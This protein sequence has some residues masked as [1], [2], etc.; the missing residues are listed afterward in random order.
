VFSSGFFKI[1]RCPKCWK[2]SSQISGI[3]KKILKV[4]IPLIIVFVILSRVA[5]NL[6]NKIVSHITAALD[7]TTLYTYSKDV[8]LESVI[9]GRQKNRYYIITAEV[10]YYSSILSKAKLNTGEP[11]GVLPA[12]MTAELGS[13][14][15]RGAEVWIPVSFYIKDKPQQAFALFPRDWEKMVSVYNWDGEVKKIRD[16]YQTFV[17]KNFELMEVQPKDEK[18]YKEKYNDYYKVKDVGDK[19]FFYASRTDKPYID[20][21]YSYY[22]GRNSINAVLLQADKAWERP[23][24]EIKKAEEEK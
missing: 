21:V 20:A 5:P 6:H 7:S 12:K 18:A 1:T 8:Y 11:L 23:A 4:S 10:P 13:A 22:L 15:R 2:K 19:T 3:I 14:I 24:L 9:R 17:K 16:A